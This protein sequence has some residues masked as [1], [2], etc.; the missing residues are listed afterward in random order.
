MLHL[1]YGEEFVKQLN[2]SY[3]ERFTFT[4]KEKD[5]ETGYYYFGARFDNVD[6]GF[7]SVDPMSDKYPSMSPYAYCAW[8]PIKLVDQD[9]NSP[10]LSLL[11]NSTGVHIITYQAK[12]VV[13]LGYGLAATWKAGIAFDKRGITRFTS[14]ATKYIANQDLNSFSPNPD[15]EIGIGIGADISYE[16]N[17]RAERF[18]DIFNSQ[19]MS[20]DIPFEIKGKWFA[21]CALQYGEESFGGKVGVGFSA[22]ISADN[23]KIKESISLSYDEAQKIGGWKLWTVTKT[24]LRKDSKGEF[25]YTGM[26]SSNGNSTNIVVKCKAVK[27]N[28]KWVPNNQWESTEY[29]K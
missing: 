21:G 12:A 6:L 5:I 19:T 8:N 11:E 15:P 24:Q 25:Y 16:Y 28:N 7:M 9:G 18:S 23:Y 14:Y 29:S 1:P 26:V 20:T 2:G 27:E 3:D 4:G 17:S 13:G 10:Y 22:S